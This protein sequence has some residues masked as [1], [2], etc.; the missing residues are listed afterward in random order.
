MALN[1]ERIKSQIR[2]AIQTAPFH[3]KLYRQEYESDGRGGK[4]YIG[5]QLVYEGDC[6]FDNSSDSAFSLI[7][8]DAGVKLHQNSPYLII[9]YEDENQVKENDY[10]EHEGSR[11]KVTKVTDILNQ[12][13]YW[14]VRLEEV[15]E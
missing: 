9:V 8:S 5:E 2:K 13:I 3:L 15:K 12:H 10:F 1:I 6:L 14:Q 7:Q 4:L 11:F